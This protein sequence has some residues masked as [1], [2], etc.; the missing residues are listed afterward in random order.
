MSDS[1]SK[2][3]VASTSSSNS[4]KAVQEKKTTGKKRTAEEDDETPPAPTKDKVNNNQ[5][6]EYSEFA[7]E[8]LQCRDCQTDFTFTS[9][10]Q[11]FHASKGFENKPVRCGDCRAAK[12]QRMNGDD[13]GGGYG[14]DHRGGY[15]SRG[16]GG[17]GRGGGGGD[18]ACYN[19]GKSGH[20]S[21]DCGEARKEYGGGN[22][23]GGGGGG[24]RACYNCG[25]S[26]HM[27]RD[28]SEPRKDSGGRGGQGGGRGGGEMRRG[29]DRYK[30][31]NVILHFLLSVQWLVCTHGMNGSKAKIEYQS[32]NHLLLVRDQESN[33]HREGFP[34]MHVVIAV[35]IH[36][37]N[38]R[39]D[40]RCKIRNMVIGK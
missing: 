40:R 35:E 1:E 34:S 3:S 29:R 16:G 7:D 30:K 39:P 31:R 5:N 38:G 21:R 28:C 24:D 22:R 36:P 23:G 6:D 20:M 12:K 18:R 19:C 37:P 10:E 26:G 27:S 11:A 15:Q 9:E 14:R 4:P 25:G 13:N 2:A 17:G 33:V 8:T 32:I